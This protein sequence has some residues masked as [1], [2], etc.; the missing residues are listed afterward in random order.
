MSF[1]QQQ[2]DWAFR[3]IDEVV[4]A[5][6]R[7]LSGSHSERRCQEMALGSAE[8][9]GLEQ[10]WEPFRFSRSLYTVN[11]AHMGLGV[12]ATAVSG[13]AP[14]LA[15]PMHLMAGTSY[16][17]DS[18]RKAYLLRRLCPAVDSQNLLLTSPA[19][20]TPR[21]R[22]VFLAHAD[23]AFTGLL[24][25]EDVVKS[26]AK[27]S[28]PGVLGYL[29]NPVI[30]ATYSQFL[31]A[32]FDLL[33]CLG[34]PLTWPLRPLEWLLT[35]PSLAGFLIHMELIL[36]DEI[37]PGANDNLSG[38]A[39]MLLL[40]RTLLE[41]KPADVEFVFVVT[42][43]EESGTGGA[44][45]LCRAHRESWSSDDTVVLAMDGLTGGQLICTD[46]GELFPLSPPAWLRDVVGD[47]AAGSQDH[48]GVHF[49][50]V[51]LGA[52]D[53]TPFMAAGY[54]AMGMGCMRP[55]V[56]A[57]AHYHQPSD[58]PE[59][60]DMETLIKSVDFCRALVAGIYRERLR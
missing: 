56:G 47:V 45:H 9:L 35:L 12:A 31:L 6:P 3:F 16:M 55:E 18:M 17:L 23:A 5:C 30:F 52:S 50:R 34:G 37:V 48:R 11:A 51:P 54:D 43:A 19:Q 57:P 28:L 53:A 14:A 38:V 4:R 8:P 10:S 49:H 27:R 22:L 42:G 41:Q 33:R 2:A 15:L 29:S 44:Y 39:G 25:N 7:R 1:Q 46:E 20:G 60:L 21:L 13:L 26:I 40:A 59:N 32:G 36:R 24:F 58:T